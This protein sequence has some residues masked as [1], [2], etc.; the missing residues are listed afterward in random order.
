MNLNIEIKNVLSN[1]DLK[2]DV[3]ES[4]LNKDDFAERIALTQAEKKCTK[5]EMKEVYK[6]LGVR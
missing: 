5:V 3:I 6:L 1:D 2:S 4:F